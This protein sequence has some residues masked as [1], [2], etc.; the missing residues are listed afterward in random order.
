MVDLTLIHDFMV[1][2][3]GAVNG[4]QPVPLV[5][6]GLVKTL[7]KGLGT[8]CMS[9]KVWALWCNRTSAR[10]ENGVDPNDL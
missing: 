8:R 4:H 2:V 9:I 10:L 3:Y 5:P 1:G 6:S 7:G